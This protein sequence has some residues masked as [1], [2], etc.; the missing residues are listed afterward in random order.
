MTP[1]ELARLQR[2]RSLRVRLERDVHG[3]LELG[4]ELGVELSHREGEASGLTLVLL[5]DAE[6]R[7]ELQQ[8]VNRGRGRQL[9]RGTLRHVDIM[10]S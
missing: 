9:P 6:A 7:L 8:L 2:V 3:L 5:E 10:T 4:A 1:R